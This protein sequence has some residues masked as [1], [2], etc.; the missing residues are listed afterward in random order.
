ML[1][2]LSY[3][4]DAAALVWVTFSALATLLYIR[5]ERPRWLA[6]AAFALGW[7][8]MTRWVYGLAIVPWSAAVL[9]HWHQSRVDR[10]QRL[11]LA[12]LAV[13]AAGLVL[14]L[15]FFLISGRSDAAYTGN[16]QVTEWNPT[17]A[18][19]RTVTYADGTFT[20]E[21]PVGIFYAL[22]ILHPAF[23]FPL[24]TPFLLLGLLT[25]R[26]RPLA[27]TVL[28]LGWP[29]SMY[30]F[31]VGTWENPRFSLAFF[32]PLAILTGLGIHSFQ[33]YLSSKQ[34]PNHQSPIT[35]HQITHLLTLYLALALLGS[36]AWSGRDLRNFTAANN[37]QIA[38]VRWVEENVPP[39]A[40]VI[41]FGM[42]LTM[43]HRT[44]LDVSEIYYLEPE[45]LHEL[46]QS[47]QPLYLC[48]NLDNINSQWK[49][50]VPQENYLWLQE[51]S[52]LNELFQYPPYTLFQVSAVP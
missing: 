18:F 5:Q 44:A 52:E 24:L 35:N 39:D 25:F 22:P 42:T 49:G 7:A 4:S 23:I 47:N 15:Q 45:T 2:S 12:G 38:A 51:N 32:P 26:K 11:Q 8:V 36:L 34:L 27:Q 33:T 31:L 40:T 16:L 21:R 41:T 10:R 17:N 19:K 3:M 1:S 50:L 30:L 9:L 13:L 29:L 37:A 28:L 46:V 43:Q 48:L 14:A 6:L 20:Y